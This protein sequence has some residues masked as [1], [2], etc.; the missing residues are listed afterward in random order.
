[1]AIPTMKR[2]TVTSDP[3]SQS[4]LAGAPGH[5]GQVIE[6]DGLV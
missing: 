4:W 3:A 2:V 5:A 1:M 6:R